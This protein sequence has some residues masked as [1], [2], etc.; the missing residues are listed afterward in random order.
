LPRLAETQV[1]DSQVAAKSSTFPLILLAGVLACYWLA[2]IHQLGAQWSVFAQYHYGWIVPLLCAYLVFRRLQNSESNQVQV[3]SIRDQRSPTRIRE[4]ILLLFLSALAYA[5]TRLLHEANPIWRLTSYLLALEVILLTF[6]F[7]NIIG[8]FPLARRL[9]FPIFFFLVAVPWPSG[10]ENF[11]VQLLTRWNVTTTVEFLGLLGVPAIQHGN[12]I[13]IGTGMVGIDDA[14]SGIRSLQAT[15]MISLFLGEYYFLSIP[16]RIICVLAGVACSFPFNVARTSFL[17][18][19]GATK[20]TKAIPLWHDPA[21]VTILVACFFSLW[22]L[23]RLLVGRRCRDAQIFPVDQSGKPDVPILSTNRLSTSILIASLLGLWLFLAEVGTEWWYRSHEMESQTSATWGLSSAAAQSGFT[24]VKI[25][26]DVLGQFK[27]DESAHKLWR[28]GDGNIWQ[29]FYFR[30]Q[31][32]ESLENRVAVQLAKTH[33]PEKCLPAIG[34]TFN[35]DL[36]VITIPV[37]GIDLAFHQ[38]QFI[39]DGQPLHVFYGLY[40]DTTGPSVLANRRKD[41]GSRI[42]AALAGSRN[43]GQRFLEIAIS[44]PEHPADAKSALARSLSEIITVNK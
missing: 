17:T 14:C 15:F 32:S 16:R 19:V 34:M 41:T 33:G 28:D 30:W 6:A 38:F 18:W 27:A 8:G 42:T 40:E 43:F 1:A 3:S 31:P 35:S 25:S 10:I 13:E 21:G 26:S 24:D 37:N 22:L 5:P 23:S 11:L 44:G 4:S 29:L 20:G 9:A 39:A 2:V 36:G 12:V 7:V